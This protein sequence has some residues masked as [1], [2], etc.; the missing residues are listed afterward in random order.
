MVLNLAGNSLGGPSDNFTTP[1]QR[2]APKKR[3]S[4]KKWGYEFLSVPYRNSQMAMA[5]NESLDS[6]TQCW[7]Y[8]AALNATALVIAINTLLVQALHR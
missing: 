3:E 4:R 2:K 8:S 7:T 5:M 6:K 1:S